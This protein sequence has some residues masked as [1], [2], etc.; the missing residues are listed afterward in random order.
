[1]VGFLAP[2]IPPALEAAGAAISAYRAWRLAQMAQR[3]A[4]AARLAAQAKAAAD[5]LSEADKSRECKDCCQVP[6]FNKPDDVS[7]EE[8]DRQLKEQEDAINNTTADKIAERRQAIRDSGGTDGVR[9][10]QAQKNARDAHRQHLREQLAENGLTG[11]ALDKAV[12]SAME[13]LAAT[14]R[15]DIIAGGDPADISG[16]AD[17]KVNSSLGSQWKGN[18]SQQLEECAKRMKASGRGGQKMKVKLKRC[19]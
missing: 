18:R 1:M 4:Q 9:D 6:C 8:F 2:A 13:G 10:P 7:D 17:A 3:A 5:A 11:R 16:L 14:H 15:L 12:E 19:K